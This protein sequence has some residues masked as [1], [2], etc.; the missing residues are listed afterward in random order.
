MLPEKLSNGLC[1][2]NPQVERLAMVA[3]MA[4]AAAGGDQE[5][6]LLPAVI[7]SHAP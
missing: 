1:S 5:L 2:L 4:I 6:P 7:W 3:D